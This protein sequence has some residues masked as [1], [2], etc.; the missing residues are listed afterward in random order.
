MHSIAII[1]WTPHERSNHEK[2]YAPY[3]RSRNPLTRF[4]VSPIH[5]WRDP[6]VV[7]WLEFCYLVHEEQGVV[8]RR[9]PSNFFFPI[10]MCMAQ[11]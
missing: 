11:D 7:P 5:D 1:F 9:T 2:H 8:S 3:R 6:H 4:A 10:Q